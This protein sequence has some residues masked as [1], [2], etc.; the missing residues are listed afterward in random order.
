MHHHLID[1]RLNANVTS[2]HH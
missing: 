1:Y 2:R